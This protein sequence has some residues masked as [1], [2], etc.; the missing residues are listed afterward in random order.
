MSNFWCLR[1]K[2]NCPN[3]NQFNWLVS[4]SVRTCYARARDNWL[5][6]IGGI[7]QNAITSRQLSTCCQVDPLNC[8]SV[9]I[10]HFNWLVSQSVTTYYACAGRNWLAVTGGIEQNAITGRQ[11]STCCQVDLLNYP[12]LTINHLIG[13]LVSRLGRVALAR[14]LIARAVSY[15]GMFSRI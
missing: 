9:M 13:W 2:N 10:N 11:L 1:S 12:S 4:Q 6:V 3:D 15:Y 14:C 5:A 8:P 7:E